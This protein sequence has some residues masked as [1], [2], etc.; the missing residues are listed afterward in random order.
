MYVE[1]DAS[2][3]AIPTPPLRGSLLVS[4]F[5][6]CLEANTLACS[7]KCFKTNIKQ[8]FKPIS[9]TTNKGQ[10]PAAHSRTDEVW[11]RKKL[12]TWSFRYLWQQTLANYW[13]KF[14][15]NLRAHLIQMIA[16]SQNY[17][18]QCIT[19]AFWLHQMQSMCW[20]D[21]DDDVMVMI[22]YNIWWCYY[23][24]R[25]LPGSTRIWAS[26]SN[27]NT[28]PCR[29]WRFI[30]HQTSCCKPHRHKQYQGTTVIGKL[31]VFLDKVRRGFSAANQSKYFE[32]EN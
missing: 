15:N 30:H 2:G 27:I 28:H 18:Y 8:G 24:C 9:P 26:L 23:I 20:Y 13:G 5:P 25:Y 32:L 4:T 6:S 19:S 1:K 16:Y 10:P 3:T 7:L 31:Y 21:Y 22:C 17:I 29:A 11:R 14:P 12:K